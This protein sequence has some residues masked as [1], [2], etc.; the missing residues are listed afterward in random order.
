MY[1][2]LQSIPPRNLINI[3]ISKRDNKLLLK[4]N[5]M[6]R[7][8]LVSAMLAQKLDAFILINFICLSSNEYTNVFI[9][10][11]LANARTPAIE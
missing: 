1:V 5:A 6:T 10:P 3:C 4:P 8:M 9:I 11:A 2:V 7:K